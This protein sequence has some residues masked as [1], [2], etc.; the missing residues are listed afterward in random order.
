LQLESMHSMTCNQR[1]VWW[2]QHSFLGS[3]TM[4]FV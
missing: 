3:H 2:S 4:C 1:Q